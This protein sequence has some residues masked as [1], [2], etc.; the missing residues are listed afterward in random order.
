MQKS[1]RS[2]AH[3]YRQYPLGLAT[4][5]LQSQAALFLQD[6]DVAHRVGQLCTNAGTPL[7]PS[8]FLMELRL[9]V[10]ARPGG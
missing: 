9:L 1:G 10:E 2:V 3:P 5:E 6:G 4:P 7:D 8:S